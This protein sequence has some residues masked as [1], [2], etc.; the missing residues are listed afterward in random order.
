MT[1]RPKLPDTP[2]F[3][4]GP[5]SLWEGSGWIVGT[6]AF[7]DMCHVA[8]IRGWGYLTGRG[9][10]LA[11]DDDT[12]FEAQKLAAQFIVDAMNEKMAR[13]FPEVK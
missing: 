2:V 10:A 12:A 1:N 3:C 6:D 5:F 11:L 13:D 9:R 7:G 4:A 8:D